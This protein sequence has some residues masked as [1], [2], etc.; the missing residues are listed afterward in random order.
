MKDF[1]PLYVWNERRSEELRIGAQILQEAIDL[2]EQKST[3]AQRNVA[4]S[5]AAAEAATRNVRGVTRLFGYLDL[6]KCQVLLAFMDDRKT[7]ML[8]DQRDRHNREAQARRSS[9]VD[10][11]GTASP[12]PPPSNAEMPGNGHILSSSDPIVDEPPP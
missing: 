6:I 10:L 5:K 3:R 2:A 4:E 12:S 7:K 8:R 9:S 1:Q 11:E